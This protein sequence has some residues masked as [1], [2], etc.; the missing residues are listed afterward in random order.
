MYEIDTRTGGNMY[1]YRGVKYNPEDLKKSAKRSKN[2]K[3]GI[4]RGT[5]HAAEVIIREVLGP[6]FCINM[7]T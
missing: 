4:Y 7:F 2:S 1:I 5:K 6:P 3:Q